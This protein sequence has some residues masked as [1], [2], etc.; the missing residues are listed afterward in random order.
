MNV[1]HINAICRAT[2]E[3]LTTHFGLQVS[4]L[5][6]SAG[7]GTIPSNDIAVILGIKGQLKG[8]IVC[9]FSTDTAKKLVGVMMGG[10]QIDQLDDMGWSA[11]QEFGNWVAGTTATELSKESCI[12]DVTTPMI[13]EGESKFHSSNP[14]VTVPLDT[15]IGKLNV[16]IA[17]KEEPSSPTT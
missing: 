8:Q 11:V 1:N 7:T 6:P 13:N 14:F 4:P 3:I 16:H 10:M 2:K 12:I 17:V 5:A 15:P 9:T